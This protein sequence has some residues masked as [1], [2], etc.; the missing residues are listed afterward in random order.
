[1]F[2]HFVCACVRALSPLEA[3][4]ANKL[5]LGKIVRREAGFAHVACAGHVDRKAVPPIGHR[6]LKGVFKTSASVRVAIIAAY[7]DDREAFASG[8]AVERVLAGHVL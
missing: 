2:F 3:K 6:Q 4:P 7:L 8:R 1:M 5:P